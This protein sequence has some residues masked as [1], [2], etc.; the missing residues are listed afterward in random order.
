MQHKAGKA[1]TTHTSRKENN[2]KKK[3]ETKKKQEKLI[4]MV[5]PAGP[6]LLVLS[7]PRQ[8]CPPAEAPRNL[9][10]SSG[11]PPP[12]RLL[13]QRC[14]L[15]PVAVAASDADD[16]RAGRGTALLGTRSHRITPTRSITVPAAIAASELDSRRAEKRTGLSGTRCHLNIKISIQ[17]DENKSEMATCPYKQS[18]PNRWERKQYVV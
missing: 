14:I 12:R 16:K 15:F 3:Q 1:R 9:R 13:V 4:G 8:G 5:N 2:A 6:C 11:F 18:G 7:S 10:R 17:K